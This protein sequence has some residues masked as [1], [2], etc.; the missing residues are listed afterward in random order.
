MREDASACLETWFLEVN[1]VCFRKNMTEPEIMAELFK[2]Y[3]KLIN[4]D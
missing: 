4:N 3:Q 1:R 2:M